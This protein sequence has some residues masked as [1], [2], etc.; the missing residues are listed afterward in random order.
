MEV[1][2]GSV[3]HLQSGGLEVG[4]LSVLLSIPEAKFPLW[5]AYFSSPGGKMLIVNAAAYLLVHA[6]VTRLVL[7]TETNDTNS[8]VD[9]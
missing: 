1:K 4:T 6:H 5:S 7:S 9:H 8:K 3:G 2:K